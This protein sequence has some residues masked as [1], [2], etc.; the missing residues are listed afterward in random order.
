M[1]SAQ[2]LL[3]V[4]P[5]HPAPV[6]TDFI[7]AEFLTTPAITVSI[8]FQLMAKRITHPPIAGLFTPF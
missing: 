1:A 8:Y 6:I 2:R 3:P 7:T 5:P 4:K